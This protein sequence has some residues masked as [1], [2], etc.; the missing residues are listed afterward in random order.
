M[1]D[2]PHK[3]WKDLVDL[4]PTAYEL[5]SEEIDGEI[6]LYQTSARCKVCNLSDEMRVLVDTLLIY[7]KSYKEILRNI[8]PIQEKLGVDEKDRINYENLR[9]H[10]RKHLPTEKQLVRETIER[11]AAEKNKKVLDQRDSLLTGE[12]LLDTIV[13]MGFQDLANGY[14]RPTL[15]QT[16]KAMEMLRDIEESKNTDYRPEELINQLDIILQAIR[17]VLP[18]DMKN[19]LFRRIEDYQSK[20]SSAKAAGALPSGEDE[21]F[22]YID[23]DLD[24]DF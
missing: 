1:T 6:Y 22:E 10:F 18:D 9:N 3:K 16:M 21:D 8:L 13:H 12:A 17:E 7:P 2:N 20:N 23:D 5:L 14:V 11:R 4:T 24:L 19:A 15:S